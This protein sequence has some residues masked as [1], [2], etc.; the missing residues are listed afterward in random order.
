MTIPKKVC[1]VLISAAMLTLSACGSSGGSVQVGAKAQKIADSFFSGGSGSYPAWDDTDREAL[2]AYVTG[3]D[4]DAFFNIT[5]G[6]FFSEYMY[7]LVLYHI[8]DDMSD[9][10]KAVCE[11]YRESIITYMTFERMYLYTAEKDYGISESTL[12]GS[13]KKEIRETADSVRQNSASVF[14][15]SASSMLGED[16]DEESI[17]KLCD[18]V[19]EAV[20]RK[21]GLDSDVFYK[22]EM[23]RYIE[24][25]MLTEAVKSSGVTDNDVEAAYGQFLEAAKEESEKDP[26][27]Y[28]KNTAYMSVYIPE[29]TRKADCVYLKYGSDKNETAAAAKEIS[30]SLSAGESLSAISEKYPDAVISEDI[31]VLRESSSYPEELRSALYSL[32]NA[33]DV[34]VPAECA[35]GVYV[36]RYTGDAEISPEATEQLRSDLRAQL[37]GSTEKTVQSRIY[38]EWAEKYNYI[39]NYDLLKLDRK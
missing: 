15:T 36:V 22:W 21:C 26:A 2:A 3:T 38:G 23:I 37:E 28:D 8:D 11:G 27:G 1:A 31:T 14:Y 10:N 12:S 19:L 7:H 20:L 16:A 5:F 18:E 6:E 25:L 30:D 29:G 35:D 17:E 33:G 39:I 13:Q 4:N 34:S 32:K 9:A 24:E